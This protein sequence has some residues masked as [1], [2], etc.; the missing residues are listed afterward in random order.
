MRIENVYLWICMRFYDIFYLIEKQLE[1]NGVK[2]ERKA[3]ES[4]R[5]HGQGVGH[6][7]KVQ[8][9]AFSGACQQDDQCKSC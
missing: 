4:K 9:H 7:R 2:N 3:D 8:L 1:R 5:D 6:V